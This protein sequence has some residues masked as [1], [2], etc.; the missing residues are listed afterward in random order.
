MNSVIKNL[1]VYFTKK[2]FLLKYKYKYYVKYKY[3]CLNTQKLSFI[4]DKN[5]K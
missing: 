5:G 1:I 4:K 2:L 3:K